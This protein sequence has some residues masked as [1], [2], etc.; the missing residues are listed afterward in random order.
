MPFL[1]VHFSGC[2][3]AI[4]WHKYKV[5]KPTNSILGFLPYG[6]RMRFRQ[7]EVGTTSGSGYIL[8]SQCA[9]N[10]RTFRGQLT[11]TV[12]AHSRYTL[13]RELHPFPQ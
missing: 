11:P 3:A 7:G 6:L 12:A 13:S 4:F 1:T 2:F 8:Y 9:D 5:E 10:S